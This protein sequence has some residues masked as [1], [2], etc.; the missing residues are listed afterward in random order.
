[1]L[2]ILA[3]RL[4]DLVLRIYR[5]LVVLELASLLDTLPLILAKF[6]ILVLFLNDVEG[7]L[8]H[9]RF[10]ELVNS[11]DVLDSISQTLLHCDRLQVLLKLEEADTETTVLRRVLLRM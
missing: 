6:L 3:L 8:R 7:G 9:D 4:Q 11:D 10:D 1:M 2:F 5:L